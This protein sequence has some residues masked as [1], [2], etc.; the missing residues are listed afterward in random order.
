MRATTWLVPLG[1]AVLVFVTYRNS[2]GHSFNFDDPLDLTRAVGYPLT[3]I[4]TSGLEEGYYRPL[5]QLVLKGWYALRGGYDPVWFHLLPLLLHAT[6]SYLVYLVIK[7]G[8]GRP[9]AAGAGAALFLLYPFSYQAVQVVDALSQSLM[10][11]FVLSATLAYARFRHTAS[12]RWLIVSWLAAIAAPFS[13]E[14][15]VVVGPLMIGV[16]LFLLRERQASRLFPAV[17]SYL[18]LSLGYLAL[19]AWVPKWVEPWVWDWDSWRLNGLFFG[20]GFIYPV[21]GALKG[22]SSFWAL[23]AGISTLGALTLFYWKGKRLSWLLASLAWFTISV[24]PAWFTLSHDYVLDGPRLLYLASPGAALAWGGLVEM[25]LVRGWKGW[26]WLLIMAI[27]GQSWV[28]IQGREPMYRAGTSLISQVVEAAASSP[29]RLLVVNLPSWLAPRE[30]DFPIGHTG[31]SLIPDYV[32]LGRVAYLY[33][34]QEIPIISVAT[35]DLLRPWRYHYTPHGPGVGRDEIA[36]LVRQHS[37]VYLTQYR[38]EGLFLTPVGSVAS[39]FPQ[40]LS[41]LAQFPGYYLVAAEDEKTPNGLS[42]TLEWYCHKLSYR[43]ETVFVHLYDAQGQLHSQAD[44]HPLSG[45][46]PLNRCQAG[47]RI[48]DHRLIPVAQGGRF[49]I[50]VGIYN[51]ST[52]TR[53][54][55]TDGQ[56]RPFPEGAVPLGSLVWP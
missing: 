8:T 25:S 36:S 17:F 18:V 14:G 4:L 31:V 33:L 15:G 51:A 56:G 24:V 30:P 6:N 7:G 53:L 12:A 55:A 39:G 37:A 46:Y 5:N 32:G 21:A 29:G 50:R 19:W 10:A 22:L 42:L 43:D 47:E 35:T 44:G 38:D 20:Q 34:G 11:F 3:H 23:V 49:H 13:H 16:E 41:F 26:S 28:F 52:G 9:S 40:P 45:L 1:L 2:L 48:I 27:A 54:P